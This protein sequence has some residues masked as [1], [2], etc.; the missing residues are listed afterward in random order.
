MSCG[1]FRN[2]SAI[3]LAVASALWGVAPFAQAGDLPTGGEVVLGEGSISSG[4]TSTVIDQSSGKLAI[5]WQSFSIAAGHEVTFNQPGRS[6]VAL[7]RVVGN[8]ASVISGVLNANGQVFLVNSGGVLFSG[9]SQVNA[10]G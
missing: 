8:E 7:N 4:A 3:A 2:R 6:A 1:L 5:N 10:A 9:G